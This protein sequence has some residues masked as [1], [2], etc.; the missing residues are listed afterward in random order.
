MAADLDNETWLIECAGHEVMRKKS[1]HGPDALS[2]IE[3]LIY[4]LWVADYGMRN[5][6]DLTTAADLY[7]PFQA[8]GCRIA[9]ELS[10]PRALSAFRLSRTHLEDTYFEVFDGLCDELRSALE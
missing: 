1:E 3:R 4:C 6:G 2:P 9:E 7:P 5:G 10:L 8:E